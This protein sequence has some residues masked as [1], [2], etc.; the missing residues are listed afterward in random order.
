[1]TTTTTVSIMRP[2][3]RWWWPCLVMLDPGVAGMRNDAAADTKW[4]V[5][6]VENVLMV[7]WSERVGSGAIN[8]PTAVEICP[9]KKAKIEFTLCV[10]LTRVRYF[11]FG[12]WWLPAPVHR[13]V[14]FNKHSVIVIIIIRIITA[15]QRCGRWWQMLLLLLFLFC[16]MT[17]CGQWWWCEIEM[18]PQLRRLFSSF[19]LLRLLF[20]NHNKSTKLNG[21]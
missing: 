5:D 8:H 13:S 10:Y 18:L 15:M 7:L 9:N 16:C 12:R 19:L 17:F 1:M 14:L 11:L 6:H 20:F 3:P 21:C 2:S 4:Y